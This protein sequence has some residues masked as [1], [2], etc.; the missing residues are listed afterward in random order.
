GLEVVTRSTPER[1]STSSQKRAGSAPIRVRK[2]PATR[3]PMNRPPP[4]W[5]RSTRGRMLPSLSTGFDLPPIDLPDP[6][7]AEQVWR[8]RAGVDRRDHD[9]AAAH[10]LAQQRAPALQVQF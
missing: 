7:A 8:K 6:R 9:L 3:V 4:G 2:A 5:R 10:H 1:S